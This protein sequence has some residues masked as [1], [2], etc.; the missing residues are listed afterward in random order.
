MKKILFL[1]L[2]I[3]VLSF[4][5][6]SSW[7]S[8][9]PS[10]RP[11][12]SQSFTRPSTPSYNQGSQW[13][14]QIRPIPRTPTILYPNYGL[15]WGANRWYGWGAPMYGWDYWDPYP[16]Y[17]V[18]GLRRPARVYYYK[19]GRRDT[20]VGEKTNW[21]LGIQ[22]SGYKQLGGFVTV[23]N[24]N[25]FVAEYNESFDR[26]NSTFFPYGDITK[27]DFPLV[28][29]YKKVRSF[30]VGVGRRVKK[31]GVHLMIG[32][33]NERVRYR[34]KDALGY[35]TFPKYEDNFITAKV[36][37]VRSFNNFTLKVDYDPIVLRSTVGLGINL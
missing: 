29:D 16:M 27:V 10:P 32:N 17:D 22:R 3:P 6:V 9:P 30:Y 11:A 20:I 1:L 5:Q 35:I 4:A 7:R 15:G 36:G 21:T 2:M 24:K 12:P 14:N 8:N 28:G 34:G 18:Y 26:D 23:G 25:Y 31:T 37:V 13:R 19:D 33:F